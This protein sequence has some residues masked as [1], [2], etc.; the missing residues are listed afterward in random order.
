MNHKAK[1]LIDIFNI[2][3][4]K[5]LTDEQ[6]EF[7]QPTA[8]VRDGENR[9]FHDRLFK[10]I[11]MSD[12]SSRILVIGHGGCGK[13]T[14]LR[15]LAGK[16]S[17]EGMLPIIIEAREDIDIND[18][19]IIDIFVLIVERLAEYANN[20]NFDV[21]NMIIS[22]CYKALSTKT[23]TEHWESGLEFDASINLPAFLQFLLRIHT[24]LKTGSG[25]RE[26][27]RREVDPK[28]SEII[29]AVNDFIKGL[30]YQIAEKRNGSDSMIRNSSNIII[31]IDGL[32]KCRQECVQ[33]LFANNASSLSEINAHM[34]IACP[35]NVFRSPDG[36]S[37]QS[38]FSSKEVMPMIKTHNDKDLSPNREGINVIKEL[39]FKRVDASFFEDAALEKIIKKAGGSLRDTCYLLKEGAFEA[40]LRESEKIDEASVNFVLNK[41]AAEVFLRVNKKYYQTIKS[42]CNGDHDIRNEEDLAELLYAGAVFEYNGKKWVDL[43]PLIRDY[44]ADHPRVLN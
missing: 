16:L 14:E 27:Y 33:K 31:I 29:R 2:F 5:A 22:A 39:I 28:L 13:S 3:E 6:K 9:E 17:I 15:M 26:E 20:E 23:T 7:Y 8:I 38:Y 42:I 30:N 4:P 10:R 41:F 43:H 25:S 34:V 35:I 37:L 19:S 40:H 24:S 32:E 1:S 12:N 11:K 36:G 44:I 18:F 21:N